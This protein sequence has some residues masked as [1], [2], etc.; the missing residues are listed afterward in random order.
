MSPTD[1][2]ITIVVP[3]FQCRDRLA[4][5]VKFLNT[6]FE[7]DPDFVLV[8]TQSSDDS[9]LLSQEAARGIGGKYLEVPAGLYS[10]WN[11]GIQ[12]V[13][14]EFT[15]IST[16]GEL[17]TPEGLQHMRTILSTLQADL[18]FSPPRIYPCNKKTIA[19]TRH[20]PVFQHSKLLSALSGTILPISLAVPL[21]ILSGHSCLL[22][23]WSS[24]LFRTEYLRENPFP[25][26]YFHYGDTAWFY[27]N[28][29]QLKIAFLSNAFSTFHV[30]DFSSRPVS[31]AHLQTFVESL[32][33]DYQKIYPSSS[34][35][36]LALNLISARRALD[37]LRK[38]HPYGPWWMSWH[39]WLW[40]FKRTLFTKQIYQ[41]I[42]KY[43]RESHAPAALGP[44]E[45]QG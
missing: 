38:P 14:T 18:C 35:P 13:Q 17:I 23:S 21:Q 44:V 24:V 32:A 9:H 5:H 10:A 7:I 2:R 33:T 15:Y 41:H 3:V 34:L 36:S 16:V 37:R 19:A 40:R 42:V 11:R 31:M 8:A 26:D 43:R 28:L 20:W 25:I 1:G 29:C 30:H 39:A 27:N 45:Q 6:L 4:S 12:E 22:G